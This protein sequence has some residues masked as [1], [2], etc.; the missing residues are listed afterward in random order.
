M[1]KAIIRGIDFVES[2]PYYICFLLWV[3]WWGITLPFK[4]LKI[5]LEFRRNMSQIRKDNCVSLYYREER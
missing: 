5:E 2:I 1:M 4:Q 3:A